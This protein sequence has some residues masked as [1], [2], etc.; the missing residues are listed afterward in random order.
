L[1]LD[2]QITNSSFIKVCEEDSIML[3]GLFQRNRS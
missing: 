3:S 2:S 1:E